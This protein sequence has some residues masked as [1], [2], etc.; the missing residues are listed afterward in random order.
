MNAGKNQRFVIRG[1][2]GVPLIVHNCVQA[3]SRDILS[4]AMQTL[5]HSDI[6]MHVHDEIV[7]EADK[8][9]LVEDICEQ[10]SRIPPWAKGLLL[11]ADGYECEFYKKD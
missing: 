7:I 3:I 4:Y 9:V 11:R 5:R 2:T 10:M 6:V 1:R 8:N